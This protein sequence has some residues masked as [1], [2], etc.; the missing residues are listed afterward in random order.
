M[1]RQNNTKKTEKGLKLW[2]IGTHLIVLS[3]SYPMNT[4][5]AGFKWFS[6]IFVSLWFGQNSLSIGRADDEEEEEDVDYNVF[7]RHL[8]LSTCQ[9]S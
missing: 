8:M 1:P 6:K 2:H 4:D 7:K 5:M 3:E 9:I